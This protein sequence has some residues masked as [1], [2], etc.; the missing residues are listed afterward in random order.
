MDDETTKEMEF[1]EMMEK[2][3]KR[4]EL[5]AELRCLHSDLQFNTSPC[6]DWRMA[7][8]LE[9]LLIGLQDCEETD[10]ASFVKSWAVETYKTIGN[11]ISD[12]IMKRERVN[13]IEEEIAKLQ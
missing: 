10:V 9:K 12:R 1:E 11:N 13:E 3:A 5:Q 6:G 4:D 8:A 2:Q 7:K